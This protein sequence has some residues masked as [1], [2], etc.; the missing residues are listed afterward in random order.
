M[1]VCVSVCASSS[2]SCRIDAVILAVHEP[3]TTVSRRAAS[4]VA[5]TSSHSRT[6]SSA[7]DATF[8]PEASSSIDGITKL[9]MDGVANGSSTLVECGASPVLRRSAAVSGSH[10]GPVASTNLSLTNNANGATAD[11]CSGDDEDDVFAELNVNAKHIGLN[12]VGLSEVSTAA[13]AAL[14]NLIPA[15]L[16]VHGIRWD[17]YVS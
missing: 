14:C 6:L 9:C 3:P 15:L 7:V 4:R 2:V 5:C 8:S 1:S 11:L 10:G 16:S 17:V 12:G 13:A